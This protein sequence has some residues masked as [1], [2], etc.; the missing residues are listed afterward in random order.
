MTSDGSVWFRHFGG[1]V[2]PCT[3]RLVCFPHAGGAA[4]FFF[5][6]AQSLAPAFDVVGVQYPGR[7]DRRMERPVTDLRELA[8]RIATELR[9]LTDVPL[10]FL[11][12]SMGASVAFEVARLLERDTGRGPALLFASGRR[13]PGRHWSQDVHQRDDA[14]VV[15][16]LRRLQ[17]TKSHM[18]DDDELVRMILPAVRADYQAIETYRCDPG[19]AVRCPVVVLIGDHDSHTTWEDARAWAE[20]TS[21]E[22][23][24]H[25]FPGGHFFLTE[26]HNGVVTTITRELD[27]AL[28]AAMDV[29]D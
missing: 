26:R 18:L 12:H 23:R 7:Q 1:A 29:A 8:A 20:H 22:C 28:V 4:S 3:A 14:G 24:V 16:E 19:A 11:G 17:G 21:G 13:A 9:P 25:S 5:P 2:P 10:A 27:S 6:L 15:T